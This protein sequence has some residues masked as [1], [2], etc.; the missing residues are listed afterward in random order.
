MNVRMC[1]PSKMN[2][3]DDASYL[4]N[5]IDH[6]PGS[7][8]LC[9]FEMVVRSCR[10]STRCWRRCIRKSHS[11][12]STESLRKG[13]TVIGRSTD[14]ADF[15]ADCSTGTEDWRGSPLANVKPRTS[16]KWSSSHTCQHSPAW[17]WCRFQTNRANVSGRKINMLHE[18]YRY[19]TCCA[20]SLTF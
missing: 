13:W 19:C 20:R 16:S 8:M 5:H 15:R 7:V 2:I 10:A 12:K 14:T 6:A 11:S 9:Q 4:K 17:K 1:Y 18:F 3:L